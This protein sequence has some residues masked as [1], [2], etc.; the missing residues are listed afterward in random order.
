MWC[1]KAM[2]QK[3]TPQELIR[4]SAQLHTTL[5]TY[6]DMDTWTPAMGAMLLAGIRPEPYCSGVPTEG[7]VGLDGAPIQGAANTAFYE[8]RLI[9]AQWNDWCEDQG[10]FPEDI[11]PVEFIDWC[12]TDEVKERHATHSSFAWIDVFKNLVGYPAERVSIPFEVALHAAQAARP[13]ET[14]LSKLDELGL[15]VKAAQ[16]R[17]DFASPLAASTDKQ[18][19]N[20]FAAHRG[21]LTTEEFAAELGVEAQTIRKNHSQNGHYGGVRPSRL[22]SRRL[23]WPLDAVERIMK[24]TSAED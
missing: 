21:H 22:P 3:K 12:V 11:R 9:L 8:A 19:R 17:D 18:Q 14:I 6:L 10:Y 13:L 2:V 24:G 5:R 16:K 1:D 15:A 4:F 23:A 7:G 20:I